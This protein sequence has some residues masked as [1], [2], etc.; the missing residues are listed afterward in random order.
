MD[1]PGMEK[2]AVVITG[3]GLRIPGA[4]SPEDLKALYRSGKA[5]T[6]P[7][8]GGM[9]GF[10]G[11]K[12]DDASIEALRT[13]QLDTC[14]VL[15]LAAVKDAV[16][17]AGL[18]KGPLLDEAGVYTGCGGG[19]L[20]TIEASVL[21]WHLRQDVKSTTLLRSMANAPCA[22]ISIAWGCK[23]PSLTYAMAC[24]SAAHAVGEAMTLIQSGRCQRVIAGGTEAP[25]TETMLKVWSAMRLLLQ[26]PDAVVR[27]FCFER[28]GLLLGEGAVF[29]ILET[30]E[31]AQARGAVPLVRLSGYGAWS[32]ASHMTGP[33]TEGQ[34]KTI[35]LALK[36][37]GVAPD[38]FGHVSAHGTATLAGDISE[39]NALRA[40]FADHAPNLA[41]SAT[42]SV[43]GHLLGAAGG[44]SLLASLLAV[45]D[46]FVAPTVNFGTPDPE[47][48]LDYV[49]NLVREGCD[50]RHSLCNAFGFGGSNASLVVSRLE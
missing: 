17:M 36:H 6:R 50:I 44:V 37:A 29:F 5:A 45:R 23:G 7:L 1:R 35:G 39:T 12:V 34:A 10:A 21:D 31:A 8:D 48:G 42:K 46:G 43:H 11:G 41:V 20:E 28:G 22:Q 16:A 14:S 19:G 32:D 18:E 15:A 33:N 40:V 38:A 27:P 2:P 24:S 9:T 4:A 47:L 30:L 13:K 3:Y 25:L 26:G 49:P